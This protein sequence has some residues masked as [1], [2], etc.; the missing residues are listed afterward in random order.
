MA[1]RQLLG[2]RWSRKERCCT[3]SLSPSLLPS[4][5][6]DTI[7]VI[8]RKVQSG[9][10]DACLPR[11]HE[12][13]HAS[14][15]LPSCGQ[16]KRATSVHDHIKIILAAQNEQL[17]ESKLDCRSGSKAFR[18]MQVP[19]QPII[20]V[21]VRDCGSARHNHRPL[22]QPRFDLRARSSYRLPRYFSQCLTTPR[23]AFATGNGVSLILVL[24]APGRHSASGY[25]QSTSA[26]N[27]DCRF[28][29]HL[30]ILYLYDRSPS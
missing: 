17:Y 24:K 19:L 25:N 7:R 4:W 15:F 27:F 10:M 2:A 30:T 23:L 5:T 9:S 11:V 18:R 20:A 28:R 3:L 6:V 13:T 26:I 29:S 1:G 22:M 12:Y 8:I 16:G 14:T 21:A